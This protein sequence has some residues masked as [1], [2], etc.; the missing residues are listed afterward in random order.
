MS[1]T[2]KAM[3]NTENASV[4]AVVQGILEDFEDFQH[5]QS[6]PQ[7]KVLKKD[8]SDPKHRKDIADNIKAQQ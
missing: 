8:M 4:Q 2:K 3:S 1:T 6:K 5:S 7:N